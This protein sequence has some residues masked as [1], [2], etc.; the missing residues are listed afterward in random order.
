M[1][2]LKVKDD[3]KCYKILLTFVNSYRIKDVKL[4]FQCLGSN[5]AECFLGD[6]EVGSNDMLRKA[7]QEFRILSVSGVVAMALMYWISISSLVYQKNLAGCH[8]S[9]II[10]AYY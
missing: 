2:E 9:S 10:K 7:L 6:A 5:P 1:L 4:F 8:F 3:D